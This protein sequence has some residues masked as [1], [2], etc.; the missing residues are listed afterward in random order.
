MELLVASMGARLDKSV[1]NALGCED[2]ERYVWSNCPTVLACISR[3]EN[4]TVFVRNRI[5]EIKTLNDTTL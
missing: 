2:T 4:E 1:T 3:K 5:Q